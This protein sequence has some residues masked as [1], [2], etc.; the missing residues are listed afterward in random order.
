MKDEFGGF[1]VNEFVGIKSKM[2]KNID[3]KKCNTAKGVNIATEITEFEDGL[4]NKKVFRQ[5]MRKI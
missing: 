4:F 5:K 3:C 1:I 2:Y